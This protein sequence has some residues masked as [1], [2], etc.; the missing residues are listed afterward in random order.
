MAKEAIKG[1]IASRVP[2]LMDPHCRRGLNV[3]SP[4]KRLIFPKAVQM[5]Q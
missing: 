1:V 3:Y 4:N 2:G 5:I